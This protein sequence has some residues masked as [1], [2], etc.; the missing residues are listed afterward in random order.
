MTAAERASKPRAV[1]N[2]P[3]GLSLE[4]TRF[5][6]QIK[7]VADDAVSGQLAR[8]YV[9]AGL[10]A[11]GS[12][13]VIDAPDSGD[14]PDL[15]PPPAPSG[16]A[17]TAG[18]DFVGITTNN[19]AFTAGNGYGRT[20]V[21]G[22][23]YGGAGALPTFAS[24]V[25]A[26]EFVGEV[27]SF[28]S[29]PGTQW[30]IWVDWRTR[31]GVLSGSP[32]GG[33]NGFQVTT[34]SLDVGSDNLL[35]FNSFETDA[36]GDGLADGWSAYNG[37][38]LTATYDRPAG[39]I[40]GVAQRISWNGALTDV[41][42]SVTAF[43]GGVRGNWQPLTSYVVS[44]FARATGTAVGVGMQLLWNVS[45]STTVVLKN[46]P[47]SANWQRYAFRIRFGAAAEPNGPLYPAFAALPAVGAGT[48]LL[49]D[50][51]VEEGDN[52]SGYAGKLAANTI[53]A[54]DA[55]IGDAAI[56]NAMIVNLSATKITAGSLGVGEYI[57][58]S[59]FVPGS[60]AGFRFDGG[61][62]AEVRTVGGAR[63]FNLG[64]SGAA[65]VFKIDSAFNIDGNGNLTLTGAISAST[66]SGSTISGGTITG[67]V[68][69]TATSGKRFEVNVGGSNEARFFGDRGDGTVEQ[70]A[71]IG[72]TSA[73]D[74]EIGVFGSIG[75]SRVALNA[76]S[77][78]TAIVV[79][80]LGNTN[81]IGVNVL[82]TGTGVYGETNGDGRLSLHGRN[83]GGN[84]SSAGVYGECLN[85]PPLSGLGAGVAG[86]SS[87]GD[88]VFG[89]SG[90]GYGGRFTGNATKGPLFLTPQSSPPS[91]TDTGGVCF[92]LTPNYGY[93]LCI[94]K[95]GNWYI[96]GTDSIVWNDSG[97]GGG[98]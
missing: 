54:G 28:A 39:R 79:N 60:T 69:Q 17:V 77:S 97:G 92:L 23:K 6:E 1:G 18:I 43:S 57:Q 4:L 88:G 55:A 47:L 90:I 13:G 65:S 58:S 81:S 87:G 82:S 80:A 27:G 63:I 42:M 83:Y 74:G 38:A 67:S 30:H 78:K 46:P 34:T 84:A 26:H 10:V 71:A 53:V 36:N 94:A 2:V 86:F 44:F 19:P 95:S 41:R 11:G 51:Q 72:V 3:E 25:I 12:G 21:Y 75:S 9:N 68:L 29:E 49:D 98:S 37:N 22:A 32:V 45:P 70:L 85:D 64:A 16:V 5:L 73:G 66:I 31:D 62:G 96:V 91:N 89:S 8:A 35:G 20:V 40:S 61:G 48:L 7:R 52:L 56:T 33:V 15:T 50:F 59:G 76:T 14:E 93:Q 24:A